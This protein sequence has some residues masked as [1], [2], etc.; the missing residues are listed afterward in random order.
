MAV[1]GFGRHIV[2]YSPEYS[3]CA[4]CNSC[5]AVCALLHDGVVSP[6]HN[7]LFVKRGDSLNI[8]CTLLTCQ[9]CDDHPCYE[10][11][12]K[13]DVAM[14]IDEEGIVYIDEDGCIGCGMCIKACKFDPPRINLA[15]GATRKEWKAK[16]CDLCRTR[17]E[18][19]ACVQYCPSQ[20][21]GV[22]TATG[23]DVVDPEVTE[24]VV[25]GEIVGGGEL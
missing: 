10:A 1:T 22:D 3:L 21:L 18:G 17:P 2:Q 15:K 7:R 19:P 5:E 14:K 6:S 25:L 9:H 11:C 23:A 20:C 13:K 4:G 24:K 8:V 12:P 16:K